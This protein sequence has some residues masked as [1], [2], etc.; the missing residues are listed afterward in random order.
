MFDLVPN[1]LTMS[2]ADYKLIKERFVTYR[3]YQ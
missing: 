3:H 1:K 2:E